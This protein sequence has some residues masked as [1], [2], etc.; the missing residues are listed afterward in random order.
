VHAACEPVN[1]RE[2][3]ARASGTA[4]TPAASFG[5]ILGAIGAASWIAVDGS[6]VCAVEIAGNPRLFRGCD[7]SSR[8]PGS[9]TD[10]DRVR[11]MLC[12]MVV[13]HTGWFLGMAQAA[14]DHR[15]HRVS[16]A[17]SA[18]RAWD[19]LDRGRF[20]PD[21]IVL[22]PSLP[23]MS[24]LEFRAALLGHDRLRG[25]PVVGV[26]TSARLPV[27]PRLAARID[28]LSDAEMSVD[29]IEGVMGKQG[30]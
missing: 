28:H 23:G 6:A 30:S 25:I 12:V 24:A 11:G 1:S 20:H 17:K 10:L 16:T 15:G 21:V 8:H 26:I 27:P 13:D 3:R 4:P 19:M 9:G 5:A 14:L 29:R 2:G 7:P 18:E 22:D